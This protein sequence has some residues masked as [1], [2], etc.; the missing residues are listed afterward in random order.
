MSSSCSNRCRDCTE[1]A[2]IETAMEWAA[3]P[4]KIVLDVFLRLGPRE[5][6]MGAEFACKPW[7]RVALEEPSLWRRV[8]LDPCEPYDERWR[9]ANDDIER[10]MKLVAVDRAKG[11][12]EGFK[13]YCNDDDLLDLVQRAPS[14]KILHIEHHSDYRHGADLI[15]VLEELNL[16]EDLEIDFKYSIDW[17]ENMLESVCETC[18]DLKKLVLLYASCFD[19]ECNEDDFEK[20]PIDG[21][22]P[23]MRK[24][25]TLGLYD[26]DLSAEGLKAILDSCP[27]LENLY[28]DGYFC[29]SEMDK[30]LRMKCG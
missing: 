10:K 12:C 21:T 17:D 8:G 18:P 28:I 11:Q 25:Q 9:C 20:E 15:D 7:R 27:V 2:P 5:V 6:Q 13:G 3:L 30:E 26:C 14:L 19:N 22:I 23:V 24:L 1:P 4:R 16:L 29:K